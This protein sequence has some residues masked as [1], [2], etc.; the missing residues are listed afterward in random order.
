MESIMNSFLRKTA[1]GAVM[2]LALAATS[3]QAAVLNAT[4]VDTYNQGT[5]VAAARAITA[6]ALGAPDGKF[7]SLGLGGS[8]IFSFGQ[9]FMA[10]GAVFEITF[11][12]VSNHQES[13]DVYGILNGM[14]KLL[15]SI[16]NA[17]NGAF[18]FVGIFDQLMFVDTSPLGGGSTDGFDIDALNV[19]PAPIPLP[20]GGLLLLSAIGGVAMLRRR[21]AV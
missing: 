4:S 18:D 21:K 5:G 8:A 15:G 6:N 17:S 20:A 11:G 19:T 14:M 7:L 10:K 13:A 2:A 16:S 1:L 12:K 3:A 9:K